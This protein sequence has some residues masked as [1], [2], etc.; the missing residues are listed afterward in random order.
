[1]INLRRTWRHDDSRAGRWVE[2]RDCGSRP[3]G[4]YVVSYLANHAMH[5]ERINLR[6]KTLNAD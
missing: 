3:R 4:G 5:M 2:G 6:H 1:M